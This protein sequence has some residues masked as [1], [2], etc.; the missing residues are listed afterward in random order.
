MVIDY[1]NLRRI[2]YAAMESYFK[3]DKISKLAAPQEWGSAMLDVLLL[4]EGC[5]TAGSFEQEFDM[6]TRKWSQRPAVNKSGI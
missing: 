5:P 1:K 3:L 4:T 6:E 2:F